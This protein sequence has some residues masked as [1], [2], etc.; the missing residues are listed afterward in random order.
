VHLAPNPANG[1][2]SEAGRRTDGPE[3]A[4]EL[5]A[6]LARALDRSPSAV[7]VFV[8]S[9]LRIQWLSSS[10]AWV[11]GSDPHSRRGASSLERIHPDDVE[12]LLHGL[13]QLRAAGPSRGPGRPVPGPLRYRFQR[14]DD[15]AGSSWRPRSTISWMTRS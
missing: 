11:T 14:F 3:V 7:V 9:E 8:D 2:G 6:R 1:P 10:A 13:E 12:R 4:P 15:A 5:A